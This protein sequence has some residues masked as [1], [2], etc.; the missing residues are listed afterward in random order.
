MFKKNSFNSFPNNAKLQG[1]HLIDVS[2]LTTPVST[3]ANRAFCR[4][5]SLN[6]IQA[7]RRAAGGRLRA[8]I[9]R[10][11]CFMTKNM[12]FGPL[13]YVLTL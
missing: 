13:G 8:Q 10:K 2:V 12:T 3:F 9:F 5:E 4:I 11:V 7:Q 1:K 6:T